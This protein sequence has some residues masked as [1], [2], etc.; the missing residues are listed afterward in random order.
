M[1]R[2]VVLS[3]SLS[4]LAACGGGGGDD[5]G[6]GGDDVDGGGGDEA[7]GGGEEAD[8]GGGGPFTLTE[9]D[10]SHRVD[11]IRGVS[12]ASAIRVGAHGDAWVATWLQ[13]SSVSKDNMFHTMYRRFD[14]AELG[15]V[16]DLGLDDWGNTNPMVVDD[17]GTVFFQHYTGKPAGERAIMTLPDGDFE[18]ED[19]TVVNGESTSAIAAFQD[20]AVSF[21]RDGGALA[22]ERWTSA[23]PTWTAM[24]LDGTPSLA[25]NLRVATNDDGH[26]AVAWSTND[27]DSLT[28][29]VAVHD[30]DEW[31]DIEIR[32]FLNVDGVPSV[33]EMAMRSDGDVVFV[34]AVST[35]LYA[36]VF[37]A[38]AGT[39]GE[40]DPI[41]TNISPNTLQ[42]RI[43]AADRLTVVWIGQDLESHARRHVG[44]DWGTERDFGTASSIGMS[45][46]RDGL[47]AVL[48]YDAP[49]LSITRLTEADGDT[50]TD[51]VVTGVGISNVFFVPLLGHVVFDA[52]GQPTTIAAQ[53]L[54]GPG[55]LGLV[56][57][58]C[59]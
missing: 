25:N 29:S 24:P 9:C 33:F 6:N 36:S 55:G 18:S 10:D 52:S 43:D 32:D 14:G 13:A 56:Y 11:E 16:T 27:G 23:E 57:T 39:F 26:T 35:T 44:G 47:L 46:T 8:G 50:F 48:V 37:D 2:N 1:R 7:D 49:D 5:D 42:L 30:G 53:E 15:D 4:I 31:S 28:I 58:S 3:L 40:P 59:H 45:G 20:G 38:G 21:F 17:D 12:G 22:V 51:P 41:A 19:Y 34:W 54:E